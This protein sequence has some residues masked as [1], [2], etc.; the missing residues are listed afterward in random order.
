ML[1]IACPWCG[2]RD[3]AEFHY[4]PPAHHDHPADPA[5]LSDEEWGRYLFFHDNTRGP[6][7]ERCCH[8]AGCRRWFHTVRDTAHHE[9]LA[10]H[11]IG[12]PK[13]ETA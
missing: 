8:S 9:I 7:A 1:L 3:E 6:R 5:L 4:G 2:P 10:V 11:R 13:P 12:E